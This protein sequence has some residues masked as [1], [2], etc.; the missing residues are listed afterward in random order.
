MYRQGLGARRIRAPLLRDCPVICDQLQ[1][2]ADGQRIAR[3]DR[4]IGFSENA[5]PARTDA[6]RLRRN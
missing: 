3:N 5:S 1:P 4:W 2:V 6:N